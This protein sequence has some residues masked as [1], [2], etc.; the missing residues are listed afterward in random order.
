MDQLKDP[1]GKRG[2]FRFRVVADTLRPGEEG[3]LDQHWGE[4][5]VPESFAVVFYDADGKQWAR[6]L[7]TARLY[8]CSPSVAFYRFS[9]ER[10]KLMRQFT[11]Q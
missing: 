11:R 1:G 4:E 5:F 7:R 8:E 9:R 6:D 10:T 3:E 2:P